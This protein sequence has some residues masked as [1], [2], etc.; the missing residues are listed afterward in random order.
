MTARADA[1]SH[2]QREGA[3]Q[4]PAGLRGLIFD[5]DGTLFDFHATWGSWSAGFIATCPPAGAGAGGWPMRCID[6]ETQRFERRA[7]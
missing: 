5:K 3:R 2:Y 7:R 6:L 1:K 4:A